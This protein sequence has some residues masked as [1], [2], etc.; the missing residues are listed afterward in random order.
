ML[1]MQVQCSVCLSI[2]DPAEVL[3]VYNSKDNKDCLHVR[4]SLYGWGDASIITFA[5]QKEATR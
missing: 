2:Y 5:E 1:V 3:V 4:R